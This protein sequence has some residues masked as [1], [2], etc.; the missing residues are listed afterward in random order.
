VAVIVN[1]VVGVLTVPTSAVH[2]TGTAS[3]V[4][5]LVSGQSVP[6]VVALGA[7]DALRTE[8]MSGINPGDTIVV[9]TVTSRVPTTSGGNGL[10]G[11]GG[12]GGRGNF[13]GGGG[14]RQ[15]PGQ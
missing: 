9:A 12:G 2:T 11:G 14:T 3:T 6:R 10:F 13:G 1:Q 7:S 8:V 4:D 15:A 5:V